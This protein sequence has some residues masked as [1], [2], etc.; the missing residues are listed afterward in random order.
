MSKIQESRI[1]SRKLVVVVSLTTILLIICSVLLSIYWPSFWN[2]MLGASILNIIASLIGV[3]IGIL[4]ALFIVQ[5]YLDDK[6]ADALRLKLI[7][8][9]IYMNNVTVQFRARLSIHFEYVIHLSYFLLYGR[10]KWMEFFFKD[11]ASTKVP[12]RIP[13]FFIWIVK[14]YM[15]RQMTQDDLKLLE[16][17]FNLV[18]A[19][20][21]K[22]T[23][24]DIK[25]WSHSVENCRHHVGDF[26]FLFQPFIEDNFEL[27]RNLISYAHELDNFSNFTK[28]YIESHPGNDATIL[29][30]D[31]LQ[32]EIKSISLTTIQ[33]YTLTHSYFISFDG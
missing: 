8:K 22:I 9:Q 23:L 20:P 6:T 7:R 13:E 19:T 10:Q 5:K 18:N 16:K 4:T 25:V 31:R 33:I 15:D 1:Q 17:E 26:L 30:D 32:S 2:P 3:L 12:E 28:P 24:K 29:L 11:Q 27:A 14:E 21:I